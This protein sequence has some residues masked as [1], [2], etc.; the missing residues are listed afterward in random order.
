MKKSTGILLSV[1]MATSM[2][3]AG[4]NVIIADDP[5]APVVGNFYVGAG[6]SL[7]SFEYT[8]SV[9][10]IVGMG[11]GNVD[12]ATE[13][14]WS[15]GTILAGYEFN[16]YIAIEGRYTK[17]FGDATV[18]MGANL[19]AG[20]GA[21]NVEID[22]TAAEFENIAIY[23]KPS[24]KFDAFSIYGLL[25]YGKTTMT[26]GDGTENSDSSFQYGAG[27]SY[28]FSENLSVFADYVVMYDDDD[29]DDLAVDNPYSGYKAFK[30]DSITAGLIYK[31]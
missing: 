14:E 1:A 8:Q 13:Y 20:E 30:A 28:A 2:A 23:L 16:K 3:T 7:V 26:W 12:E 4:K 21:V 5:I 9:Y 24:I 18:T 6:V 25:G 17:S 31:F 19:E 22:Q 27:A 10:D 29:F 15:A 11:G